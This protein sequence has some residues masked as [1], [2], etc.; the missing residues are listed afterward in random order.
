[1]AGDVMHQSKS[2][3]PAGDGP[4][5]V[6]VDIWRIP[7]PLPF[8]LRAV[9]TYLI[10]DGTSGWTLIDSGLGLAADEAA[11]RAGLAAAGASVA[12]ITSLVLTHAH[13]DHV[14]LSGW[15][16]AESGAPVYLL[17]GEDE[18][19]YRVWHAPEHRAMEAVSRMYAANGLT[20]EQVTT[21][22]AITE[23]IRGVLRLPPRSA[24]RTL[25][26]GATVTLGG[27][28]YAVIWT[29]GH[30]DYH[31]VLLRDDGILLA[32]DHVLP[33]ITP[34]IG[35]YP[36]S[37]PNPLGDYF[38]SLARVRDLPARLVLPGHGLPF[39]TLAN[40]VDALREHHE[41]RSAQVRAIVAAAGPRGASAA[42]VATVLFGARLRTDDD[43]RF[44]VVEALAH[45]EYLHAAAKLARRDDEALVRFAVEPIPALA[46]DASA[47][48]R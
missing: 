1:M 33:S 21:T 46:G 26:D 28:Q 22:R 23:R 17:A 41:E 8:A 44:A 25:A 32:G 35:W 30:S 29:P 3:F 2:V 16:H 45:L 7:L 13:P 42:Q 18:A 40:R 4:E 36:Q 47:G 43:R 48:I 27:H 14:G 34:N 19:L 11:L 6:A 15:V 20:A 9:N 5:Q 24:V 31:M 39:T 12:A 10:A 38:D 37:R